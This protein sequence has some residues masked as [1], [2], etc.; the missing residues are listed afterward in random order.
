MGKIVKTS[1]AA[2]EI[3][4]L[5]DAVGGNCNTISFRILWQD[6]IITRDHHVMQQVLATSFTDF[7]KGV[8]VKLKYALSHRSSIF[9]RS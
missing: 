9:F 8:T 6:T 3:A 5:F 1:Y 7:E 4:P 2:S